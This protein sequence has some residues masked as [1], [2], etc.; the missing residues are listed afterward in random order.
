M[1]KL[2]IR[3]CRAKRVGSILLTS[4]FPPVVSDQYRLALRR[5]VAFGML[6]WLAPVLRLLRIVFL[7]CRNAALT[8][9]SNWFSLPSTTSSTSFGNQPD[10][11]TPNLGLGRNADGGT[12]NSF[13]TDKNAST[14]TVKNPR[15]EFPGFA[16]I[17]STTSF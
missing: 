8:N 17:R 1:R 15:S 7:F 16:T 12:S 10:D 4:K 3:Q 13:S 14:S 5:A 6:S 2:Q 11:R 9:L